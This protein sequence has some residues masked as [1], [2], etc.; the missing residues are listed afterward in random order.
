MANEK[1]LKPFK[2]GNKGGPGRPVGWV[3]LGKRLQ[4]YLQSPMKYKGED[5][6]IGDLLVRRMV[7][8]ALSGNTRMMDS[9]WEKIEG[10]A[11]ARMELTGKDGEPIKQSVELPATSARIE[12]ILK[13][14]A[15]ASDKASL[16]H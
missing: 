1:N 3:P 16:P 14:G 10:K 2:K 8:A 7:A 12:E 13:R 5:K 15:T 11:I 9:I 6:L 4:E